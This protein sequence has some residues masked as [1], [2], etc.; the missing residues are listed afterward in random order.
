MSHV[1]AS[2]LDRPPE[3]VSRLWVQSALA[4]PLWSHALTA[5]LLGVVAI[6]V[7]DI[8]VGSRVALAGA[9][10]II[11]L[12]VGL[13]GERG[14]AIVVACVCVAVAAASG[15]WGGW[16]VAWT[17]TLV[18][19]A[20]SS[21]S[22]VL[23][24]ML[25]AAATTTT[26]QLDVLRAVSRLAQGSRSVEEVAGKLLE[27]LVP[28]YADAA[29]LDL[30]IQDLDR[31]VGVRV[32]PPLGRDAERWLRERPPVHPRLPGTPRVI[33]TGQPALV[34]EVDDAM[35]RELASDEADLQKLRSL[36]A[37]SALT[38]PLATRGAPFGAV[39][40]LIG[41][42]GR[43]YT[44]AD[45][46]FAGLVQGRMAIVLDNTGL[47]RAAARSEAIM[48]AA[49]DTLEEA[50]TMN[51]PD[52]RTVY[53]NQAAVRLLKAA[54]ADELLHGRPGDITARF[55]IYDEE[56]NPVD[57]RDLPAF[58]AISGEEHPEP[59]LV[60][61]VVIATGEERW[62][63]NKVS[64]LRDADG[65]VD[66]IVNVIVDVT[67]VKGAEVRQ[68]LLADATRVLSGGTDLERILGDVA[69]VVVPE[70]AG[71]CVLDVSE[72]AGRVVRRGRE[73]VA[74]DERLV[75][76]LVAGGGT[77]GTITLGRARPFSVEE[78]RLAEELGHRA[79]LA[80]LNARL[81]TE[82]AEI[83]RDLQEGLRPPELASLRGLRT[84]T[85]Y[86]PAG[87]LNDVGGDFYD[88][89]PTAGAWNVII[90]DVAG[91]GAQ[92]ATLTGLT[93][94][95][96]RSVAQHAGVLH[97]AF[98][99]VNRALVDQAEMALCTI[100]AL[101]LHDGP[102]GDLTLSSL[103][104]GHPLPLLI[105]DGTVREVGAPGPIAGVF[106][107][108]C[109]DTTRTPLRQGDTVLLYT[110][111]VLDTVGEQDRFG[112]D[113][114]LRLLDGAPADPAAVVARIDAAL[115]AF[116]SGP[117]RDDTAIVAIT[118]DDESTLSAAIHA[119]HAEA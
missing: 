100:A 7:L 103:S 6:A 65:A 116:Q 51:G 37:R 32:A 102:G 10:A 64:V 59:R 94:Y 86:R 27:I 18:V 80:V 40:L 106:E 79:G 118:V 56:G 39:S 16:N 95:T 60:R 82:R 42:S 31:R 25:R 81:S 36:H 87:E 38:L 49:L 13:V 115:A 11:V 66:R 48:S 97:D 9:L 105:R 5:G 19:I 85:L 3:R 69:E 45:L 119:A 90:G 1:Q 113:R 28:A 89:F 114:L 61:N 73:A 101:S 70:L 30:A 52:G 29:M 54:S 55:A 2:P 4:P 109:W 117:Q 67:Q 15:F 74:G 57:F 78:R 44:R 58:R 21:V 92:A 17:V 24:S 12:A 41:A 34:E 63:L 47:S 77:R 104:A 62:L 91:Q 50:V 46:E 14:D 83:T 68:R 71:W 35:L 99:A 33:A 96:L 26:R 107:D 88:A 98:A 72:P 111:G 76:P 108:A 110:D 112:D 53:V 93:R 8:A 22:A 23:V 75:A 43:R 84:A 20:A